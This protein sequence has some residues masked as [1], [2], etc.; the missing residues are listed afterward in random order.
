M[1]PQPEKPETIRAVRMWERGATITQAAL[2]CGIRRQTL[3]DALRRRGQPPGKPGRP[4]ADQRRRA[5][6]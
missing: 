2:E 3:A 4:F 1:N 6:P 5:K